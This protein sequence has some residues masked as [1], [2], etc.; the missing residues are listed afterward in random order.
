MVEDGRRVV[1]IVFARRQ[2]DVL[3]H[4][5]QTEEEGS[6]AG[7]GGRLHGPI[8]HPQQGCGGSQTRG[9]GGGE[10]NSEAGATTRVQLRLGLGL[11][12]GLR[13]LTK[14][15]SEIS[16]EDSAHFQEHFDNCAW[17]PMIDR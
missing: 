6:T 3:E 8:C 9:G 14:M 11:G 4:V 15:G 12:L 5:E 7:C 1:V 10:H 2:R 17:Q 13:F 16:G